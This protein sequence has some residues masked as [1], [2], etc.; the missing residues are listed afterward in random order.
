MTKTEARWLQTIDAVV[1][2]EDE[3]GFELDDWQKEVSFLR[4]QV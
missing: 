1:F 2:A 3:L 4:A